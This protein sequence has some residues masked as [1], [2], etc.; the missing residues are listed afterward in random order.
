MPV[1]QGVLVK[2]AT[3]LFKWLSFLVFWFWSVVSSES[4]GC[5]ECSSREKN[6]YNHITPV[7]TS[8]LL[9]FCAFQNPV[10]FSLNVSKAYLYLTCVNC[11]MIQKSRP[12]KKKKRKVFLVPAQGAFN[13]FFSLAFS[14]S[15]AK[16]QFVFFFFLRNK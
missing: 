6:L 4:T 13:F 12:K 16:C 10:H 11:W 9:A 2:T 7:L 5:T 14:L 8:L 1:S 15:W 3:T